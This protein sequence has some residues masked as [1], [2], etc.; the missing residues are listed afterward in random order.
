MAGGGGGGGTGDHPRAVSYWYDACEDDKDMSLLCGINFASSTDFDP[1]LMP[2]PT[3][4][5]GIDF[6]AS[7][8]FD[9][10][11]MPAM[12]CAGVDDGLV[13]EIDRIL[14]SIEAET[15]PAPQ[16]PPLAPWCHLCFPG[17]GDRNSRVDGTRNP[18]ATATP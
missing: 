14:E 8:D 13:A 10:G 4:D 1:G 2:L 9:P 15:A 17:N 18:S 7:A 12:D 11:F 6:A 3:M 16:P 5:C